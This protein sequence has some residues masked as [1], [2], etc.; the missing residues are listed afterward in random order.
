MKDKQWAWVPGEWG[1]PPMPSSVWLE[2]RYDEKT[3]KWSAPYWQA[4]RPESYDTVPLE[5]EMEKK[6]F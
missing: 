4:D 3:K 1:M 5:K 6:K 2:G